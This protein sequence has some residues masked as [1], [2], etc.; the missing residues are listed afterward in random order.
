MKNIIIGL[1]LL[2]LVFQPQVLYAADRKLV[3]NNHYIE[4][5][6][7]LKEENGR[8]FVPVRFVCEAAGA[9]ISYDSAIK[10]VFISCKGNNI[11]L[12]P[13]AWKYEMNGKEYIMELPAKFENQRVLVPLSFIVK[14]LG[15]NAVIDG[16]Y[17][18]VVIKGNL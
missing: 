14:A 5:D 10:Y 3:V 4:T 9:V 2:I 6:V 1:T 18:D 11:K 12:K 16:K 15:V 7:P 13:G 17:G 8:I